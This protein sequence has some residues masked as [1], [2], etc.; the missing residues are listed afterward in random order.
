[1]STDKAAITEILQSLDHTNDKSWTDDGS[2][3]VTEI[4]RLAN[5]KTITRAQINDALP[6]FARNSGGGSATVT[7]GDETGVAPPLEAQAT[8]DGFDVK[9]EPDTNGPGQPLTEAEVKEVLNRRVRDAEQAIVDARR[10]LSDAQQHMFNMEKRLTRAMTDR[11]RRFPPITEAAN[12]KEHLARQMERQR[13]AAGLD[14]Q[15][16]GRSQVDISMERSNRRGWTRPTR[17]VNNAA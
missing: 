13:E 3:L 14:P 10:N 15:T 12:I 17:P 1:M 4:Q 2:P 8:D 5:D 9:V 16:G 7:T 11:S 6:G